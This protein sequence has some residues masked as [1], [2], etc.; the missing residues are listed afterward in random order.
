M[1]IHADMKMAELVQLNFNVLAVIQ[2]LQIPFGFKDKSVRTI[3]EEQQMPVTFFMEL[4]HWFLERENFPQ[5][6]LIKGDAKWLI[7]YLHNT[8]QYYLHFQIP[9]IEKEIEYLEQLSGMPD[10]SVQLMLGFFREY[11]REF[12]EHIRSEEHTS[13]LQ[14][15]ENLVCRLLL[16]KKK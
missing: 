13:E 8:H 1:S 14:S 12:T 5:E 16:E 6:Q 15:R 3:C 11:I 4:V 9:R 2:R 7:T 10:N